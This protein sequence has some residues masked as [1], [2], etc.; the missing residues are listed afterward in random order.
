MTRLFRR[1]PSLAQASFRASVRAS[2]L[3][4]DL[5]IHPGIKRRAVQAYARLCLYLIR[6]RKL[7]ERLRPDYQPLCKRQ[8]LS[9][10]Y[11]R[12]VQQSNV[13]VVT[14][15]IDHVDATGVVTADGN[16]HDLDV[17]VLATG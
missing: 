12:A 9:G 7:R 2:A 3:F 1:R 4:T 11:F 13:E 5:T 8:V 16:H 6:D 15:R 10:N 17:V 14:E